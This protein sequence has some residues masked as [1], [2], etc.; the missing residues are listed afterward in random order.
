MNI[1]RNVF[2]LSAIVGSTIIFSACIDSPDTVDPNAQI[3]QDL[4]A[5]DSYL[6]AQGITAVKDPYIRMV[7][8]KLGNKLPA[9][10]GNTVKVTYKG[11]LFTT[12]ATFDENNTSYTVAPDPANGNQWSVIDG[13]KVALRILP[14]GSKAKIYIP[15]GLAYG[16]QQ[17]G[18]IPANSILVF[19][20]EILE[21]VRPASFFTKIASDSVAIDSYL[22][23]KGITNV[24][25]DSTGIR[26]VITTPGTGVKP[27]WYTKIKFNYTLK[28]LTDD[29]KVL[30]TGII[31]PNTQF[32]SR[33]VDY[34]DGLKIGFQQIQKGTKATFYLPSGLS[35]GSS[36]SSTIPANS[37]L[38]FEIEFIDI[39]E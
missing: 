34:I 16:T 25:K 15:S 26:Y 39:I 9:S 11:T 38:I 32:Y 12:G 5:I 8:T 19:D 28:L 31:E 24:V 1:L 18:S 20:I 3:S 21:V 35:Y 17:N 29:T 13:W 2:L 6:T 23:S 22:D 10:F 37:N 4:A 14:E 33:V 30:E 7:I 36:A 27:T